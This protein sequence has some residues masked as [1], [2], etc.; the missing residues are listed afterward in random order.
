MSEWE[1]RNLWSQQADPNSEAQNQ[2]SSQGKQCIEC[3]CGDFENGNDGFFYCTNCG[4][5]SQDLIETAINE[6][7]IGTL[8]ETAGLYSVRHTARYS[9]SSQPTQQPFVPTQ[10]DILKALTGSNG[11]PENDEE[12]NELDMMYGFVEDENLQPGES[13]AGPVMDPMDVVEAVRLRYLQGLQIMVQMQCQVL[14]QECQ[15]SP[16]ICGIA[17][18]VWLRFVAAS[19]VFEDGW[20]SRVVEE[21]EDL[22]RQISGGDEPI[23]RR[24]RCKDRHEPHNM[25]GKRSI[26][27]W[28]RSLKRAVPLQSTLAVLFLACHVARQSVLPIDI[29][30]W[31]NQAKLP[32]INVFSNLEKVLGKPPRAC[33]LRTATLFR[34]RFVTGPWDLEAK[35]GFIAKTIGLLLPCVNFNEI[36]SRYLKQLGLPLENIL[37]FACRVFEWSMPMDLRLSANKLKIPSH[38]RLMAIL[39]VTI[40]IVYRIHGNGVWEKSIAKLSCYNKYDTEDEKE[41]EIDTIKTTDFDN[42]DQDTID[43]LSI[44]E[45]AYH[46][47]NKIRNG[48]YLSFFF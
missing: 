47:M 18:S 32:Y 37:P 4:F 8:G 46:S 2:P 3:G 42:S 41:N 20:D 17:G 19:R 27:I 10:E 5:Q 24:I 15:I 38:V 11:D 33:P 34:P 28:L 22:L 40:R 39:I 26:L 16:I 13:V 43:I 6:E 9:Q 25:Y 23:Y 36:A 1:E 14:V 29:V 48:K 35:S 21:S 12:A 30:N 45:T 7:E 44:L 31:A